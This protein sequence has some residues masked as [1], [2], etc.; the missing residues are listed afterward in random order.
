MV[1]EVVFVKITVYHY[2]RKTSWS[3]PDEKWEIEFDVRSVIKE[4]VQTVTAT[5]S[6][7]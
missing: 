2:S 1:W 6:L 5:K 4:I 7:R 3:V